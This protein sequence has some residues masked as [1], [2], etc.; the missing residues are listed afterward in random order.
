[1]IKSKTQNKFK[2]KILKQK[3]YY[4]LFIFWICFAFCS[5][6]FGFLSN[7]YALNIDKVKVSFISGDY[8]EAIKEGEKILANAAN[9][10]NIDELYYFLALSYLKEGNYLRAS[11]IFE[12]ILKEF[13]DSAFKE[14]ACLGLGDTY[15]LREEYSRAEPYYKDIL[16]TNPG[17]KLKAQI[18]YR[19]SQIGFKKGD[20][21]QAKEYLNKL[22]QELPLSLESRLNKDFYPTPSASLDFYYTVQAGSFSKKINAQNL[23]QKLI[24]NNYPA[25][26]EETAAEGETI[27]RVRIGKFQI[28]REA[29]ELERKLT[30]EGYPTKIYP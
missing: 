7:A 8:K 17:T 18:Y 1:M 25:Y 27:Y 26:I 9:S 6:F 21:E 19:L 13:K 15:L 11:D 16:A 5:L 2:I 30:Q 10:G 22:K 29:V 24:H 28:R 20:N 3:F 23:T 12:I 14:Q 4:L